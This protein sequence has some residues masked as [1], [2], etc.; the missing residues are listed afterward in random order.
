MVTYLSSKGNF[1]Q[2]EDPKEDKVCLP[3]LVQAGST[4]VQVVVR[5]ISCIV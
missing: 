1:C 5:G 4:L 2:S 3:L